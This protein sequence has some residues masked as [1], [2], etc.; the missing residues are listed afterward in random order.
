MFRPRKG[1]RIFHWELSCIRNLYVSPDL[2]WVKTY[3][4]PPDREQ[5]TE[6]KGK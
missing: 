1:Q 3:E 2:D 6:C 5:C 4:L